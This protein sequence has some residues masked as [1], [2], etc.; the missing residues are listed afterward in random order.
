MVD[1][2]ALRARDANTS[3]RFESSPRHKSTSGCG[4]VGRALLLG[5]RGRE[6]ESRHPDMAL[7]RFIT[8]ARK[9]IVKVALKVNEDSMLASRIA[10]VQA[11]NENLAEASY[12]NVTAEFENK[13]LVEPTIKLLSILRKLQGRP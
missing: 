9:N 7:D 10:K 11:E 12:L 8:S 4:S 1:T 5:S 2:R 3:W 13:I 6:F